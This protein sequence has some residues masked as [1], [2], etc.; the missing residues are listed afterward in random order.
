MSRKESLVRGAVALALAG[1]L[2]KVS[3]L[4]VRLP[5]TRLI[6][7]EG[8]GIYQMALPAFNALLHLAAGGVP[9]AVQNLVAA[10]AEKRKL[11]VADRVLHLAVLYALVAGG[12]A[13]ALLIL[14]GG[15][16]A[17][18]LGDPRAFY[19]LMA[20]A[21]AVLL[22]ALDSIY[23]NYLQG[24]KIITPSAAASVLE[25]GTKVAVTIG[26]AWLLLP[27]GREYAAA[28]AAL[29]ITG[30]AVASLAYM[31]WTV[32]R[33]RAEDRVAR[34]P[35]EAPRGLGWRMLK[36]AWPVTVGSITLPLLN[37][38][39]VGIVQQGFRRAGYTLSEATALYGAYS[40]I[41]VQVVWFPFV[42]T[43][44]LANATMPTL[45]AAQ[46]RGD[47]AAVRDRVLM[48][49]RTAGLICLPVAMGAMVLAAPI[50]RLFG[51]PQAAEPLR[52]MGPVALL[53][54]LTWMTVAQ[55]QALGET[56]EPMRNLGIAMAVKLVLDTLLAPIRGIDVKGV[57]VAS[58]VMFL[59][60]LWLNSRTLGRLLDEPVRWGRLLSG[61]LAASL[62]MGSGLAGFAIAAWERISGWEALL[63]ALLIAPLLYLG[64]LIA[65]RSLTRTELLALS[66]PLAPRLERWLTLIWPW[67]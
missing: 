54:P 6:G 40:G 12:A 17:R 65:T 27:L 43:N 59:I 22:F 4:L 36:L 9:V 7:S 30:G 13:T 28:G 33:V 42:L 53:G 3:N 50:A 38:L 58:V 63:G 18:L 25:Q 44:A 20:V 2:I 47:M 41:A 61:P 39:D 64:T 21:P 35:V 60:C 37:V 62:V 15:L 49:L 10:H 45:T 32:R 67:N 5:L 55:L 31:L 46:A 14:G 8:L 51:E 48:G 26:A 24:R 1:L 34:G 66:G 11:A 57:A 29:G 23:R 52:Y 16:L 56:A 19:P